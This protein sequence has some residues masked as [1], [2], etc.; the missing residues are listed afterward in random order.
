MGNNAAFLLM[1]L[2]KRWA[3]MV[4]FGAIDGINLSTPTYFNKNGC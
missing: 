2:L 4:D 1:G 3:Y